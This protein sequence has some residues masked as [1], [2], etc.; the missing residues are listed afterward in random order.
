MKESKKSKQ[1]GR[2][3]DSM[4]A[5]RKGDKVYATSNLVWGGVQLTITKV[6]PDY[7]GGYNCEHPTMGVGC[8]EEED[9]VLA[10][11]LSPAIRAKLAKL[12]LLKA[13]CA[14]LEK[15]FMDNQMADKPRLVSLVENSAKTRTVTLY[16]KP[17]TL[18]L[19]MEALEAR[20]ATGDFKLHK[21]RKGEIILCSPSHYKELD[22]LHEFLRRAINS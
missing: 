2:I 19:I 7:M 5:L 3:I 20:M 13:Q 11:Q 22:K 10:S 8:F 9:L 18:A 6:W 15:K 12:K 14:K 1:I 21:S 17:V 16:M 4:R